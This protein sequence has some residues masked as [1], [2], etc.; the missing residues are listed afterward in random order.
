[1]KLMMLNNEFP[2]LGGGTGTVNLALFNRFSNLENLEIDLVTS[3]PDGDSIIESFSNNIKIHRIPV[4]RYNIHHA[5]NKELIKYC[6]RAFLY[7]YQLHRK[8]NYDLCFAWSAVPS[9]IQHS[10]RT[11]VS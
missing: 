9:G 1:M 6:W 7:G 4:D 2:P 3:S 8:R 10:N 11:L 5:S